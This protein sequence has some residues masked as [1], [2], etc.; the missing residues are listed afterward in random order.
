[1]VAAVEIPLANGRAVAL[2][3]PED[4]ELVSAF[5]WRLGTGGYALAHGRGSH[6]T[7]RNVAMHR[8]VMGEPKGVQ[9]DHIDRNRLNNT[10]ENLRLCTP[11]GNAA[12]R[13]KLGIAPLSRFKGVTRHQS[14]RWQVTIR[15]RY[16]GLFTSEEEAARAYDAAALEQFGEF[17]VLNFPGAHP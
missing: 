13:G 10:R 11:L 6:A 9:V 3:S 14:G 1:M 5:A 17:A 15:T 8:I 12:N 16:L 7:R 4:A 2:V